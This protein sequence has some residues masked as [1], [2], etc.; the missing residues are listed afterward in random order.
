MFEKIFAFLFII[1]ILKRMISSK[2]H[3]DKIPKIRP[4]ERSPRVQEYYAKHPEMEPFNHIAPDTNGKEVMSAAIKYIKDT[5][6][7]PHLNSD[8]LKR[9][10]EDR[11][12]DWLAKQKK[13]ERMIASRSE[14]A[15]LKIQHEADC[16]AQKLRRNTKK[17]VYR[18]DL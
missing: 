12:N 9:T 4:E 18:E 3:S 16:D 14:M 17:K 15:T 5:V 6:K 10:L 2:K 7:E 8:G 13:E 11:E 1:Y